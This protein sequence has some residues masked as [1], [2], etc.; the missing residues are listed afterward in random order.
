MKP[1]IN[2]EDFLKFKFLVGEVIESE[3]KL[4]LDMGDKII[5][6]EKLKKSLKGKQIIVGNLGEKYFLPV[7]IDSILTPEKKIPNGS[8]VG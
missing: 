6:S 2:I 8:R 4:K 5:E 3:G 7:V 1:E